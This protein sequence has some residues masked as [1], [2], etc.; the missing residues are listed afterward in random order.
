[1]VSTL[2]A[3]IDK[4]TLEK[5]ALEKQLE[6]ARAGSF[7]REPDER[8]LKLQSHVNDLRLKLEESIK[9]FAYER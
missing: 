4:L 3:Q 2:Y 5:E 9:N 7:S 8:T 6:Q 1:M